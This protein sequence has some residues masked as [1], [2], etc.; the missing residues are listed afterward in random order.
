MALGVRVHDAFSEDLS[1]F[2][3]TLARWLKTSSNSSSK[4][5]DA[6]FWLP[7]ES[8]LMCTYP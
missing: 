8:A 3:V 1:S 7:L 2:S 5:P 4:T 6:L